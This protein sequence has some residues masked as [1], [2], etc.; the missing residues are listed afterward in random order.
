MYL[1]FLKPVF[2]AAIAF[3]LASGASA[4]SLK[5]CADPE[6]LPFSNQH[7]D[8]F[9]NH[10]AKLVA[11]DLGRKLEYYW[12]RMGRG[13][14]RDVLNQHVCDL[15]IAV[16]HGYGT[17]LTTEPYYTSTY[18]FVSRKDRG[19]SV[20]SFD[21]PVL[22]RL[23]IGVQALDDDYTPPGHALARRGYID[24]M[25]PF[26]TKRLGQSAILK[27][28]V[29]RQVDVAVIWGPV[30]GYFAGKEPVEFN[31]SFCPAVDPP[32]IPMRFAI[33]MGMRRN[34]RTLFRDVSRFI[35]Q[36]K[37]AIQAIL[38]NYHVPIVDPG[39]PIGGMQ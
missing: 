11:K 24:Q 39:K 25:V 37:L 19:L 10:I 33:S 27:A 32:G 28:V 6:S 29:S 9:E 34:D 12:I 14:V 38:K 5:V 1:R 21:D 26:S 18:V 7:G 23:K 36:K 31:E 15:V 17:M 22:S 8:G 35:V 13:F 30:A 4:E 16:P 20:R 2:F 3:L